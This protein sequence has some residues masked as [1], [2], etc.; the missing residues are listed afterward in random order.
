MSNITF[1]FTGRV[2]AVGDTETLGR[3]PSRPFTKR[4]LIVDNSTPNDK[5]PNPVPFEATGDRCAKLDGIRVGDKVEVSFFING[6]EWRGKTGEVRYFAAN[7]IASVKRDPDDAE[8][9]DIPIANADP[10]EEESEDNI[11]F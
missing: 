2:V 4:M 8:V 1:R 3:D 10:D 6:R 9:P 11:P 7:R 5:Y